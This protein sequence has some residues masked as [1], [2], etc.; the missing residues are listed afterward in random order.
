MRTI[1]LMDSV[2]RNLRQR[3]EVEVLDEEH[4]GRNVSIAQ[5]VK[6]AEP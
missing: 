5:F 2:S 4:Y 1:A 6:T 3:I